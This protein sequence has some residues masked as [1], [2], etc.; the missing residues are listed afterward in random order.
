M[1]KLAALTLALAGGIAVP[2]V[3]HAP[4]LTRAGVERALQQREN[5]GPNGH[6]TSAVHCRAT[7]PSRYDCSLLSVRH[8]TLAAHVVVHGRTLQAEWAP[9]Q[10]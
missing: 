4:P 7:G 2:F 10:G 9:L 6:V 5:D 3:H 8:T 1:L